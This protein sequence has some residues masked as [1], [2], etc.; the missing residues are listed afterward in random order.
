LRSYRHEFVVHFLRH[1]V[2]APECNRGGL[3][4]NTV[5]QERRDLQ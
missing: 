4:F 1:A 2:Y 5:K 3:K